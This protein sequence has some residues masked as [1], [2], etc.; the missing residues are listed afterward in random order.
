MAMDAAVFAGCEGLLDEFNERVLAGEALRSLA[1]N[2]SRIDAACRAISNS[3]I[4][5]KIA[6]ETIRRCAIPGTRYPER[7]RHR[8]LL[9]CVRHV[10]SDVGLSARCR[11]RICRT[12]AGCTVGGPA[13]IVDH[14]GPGA[15]VTGGICFHHVPTE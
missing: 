13:R 12:S 1:F 10:P 14:M 6:G 3:R 9:R 11:W 4:K 7:Q 8:N 15:L 2:P 5:S